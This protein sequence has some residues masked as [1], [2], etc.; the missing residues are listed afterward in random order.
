M[1]E[2][3]CSACG[4]GTIVPARGPGRIVGFKQIPGIEIPADFPI[5]TCT[6]CGVPSL[7]KNTLRKMDRALDGAYR[8]R[9]AEELIAALQLLEEHEISQRELENALGLSP[10]YLS[11]LK[12]RKEVPS[13]ALVAVLMLLAA[14]P[15]RIKELRN[16]WTRGFENVPHVVPSPNAAVSMSGGLPSAEKAVVV[17]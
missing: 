5:P 3:P 14:R 11:K 6:Q 8:E 7:D 13:A 2:R 16:Y 4:R 12:H 9:L 1:T 17:G 15:S 10:G